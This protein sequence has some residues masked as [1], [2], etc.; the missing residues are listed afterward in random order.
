MLPSYFLLLDPFRQPKAWCWY[1]RHGQKYHNGK[2]EGFAPAIDQSRL[3]VELHVTLDCDAGTVSITRD[4]ALLGGTFMYGGLRRKTLRLAAATNNKSCRLTIVGYRGP[5]SAGSGAALPSPSKKPKTVAD[6]KAKKEVEGDKA[7]K[8]AETDKA[9]KEAEANK[10]APAPASAEKKQEQPE[11]E[12]KTMAN[13]VKRTGA[14]TPTGNAQ[15]D[16][17]PQNE[18]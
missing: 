9:K 15:S 18:D 4:G 6:A 5:A 16:A 8:E 14:H 2:G 7:K 11:K 3:P 10:Q 1:V 12:T 13:K 17:V